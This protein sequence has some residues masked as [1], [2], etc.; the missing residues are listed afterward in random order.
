ML[1]DVFLQQRLLETKKEY[2]V[3]ESIYNDTIDSDIQHLASME[4]EDARKR[5]NTIIQAAKTLRGIKCQS[6]AKLLSVR[7]VMSNWYKSERV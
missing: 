7:I 4:M 2:E 5:M 1:Q 6:Q 3:A